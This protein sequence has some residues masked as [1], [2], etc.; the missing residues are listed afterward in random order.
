MPSS[1]VSDVDVVLVGAGI[2]CAT[3]GAL[4]AELQPDWTIAIFERLDEAAAESSDAWNNAG[5]GHSAFCELNYTPAGPDG[6]VDVS[7]ALKIAEQFEVSKQLWASLVHRGSLPDPGSFIRAIPH[8]S[9][10]WGEAHRDFLRR[11]YA[12]LHRSPLFK[13]MQYSE[14]PG[15][16]ARWAPLVMEGRSLAQPIAATRMGIGTDVNYGQLTRSLLAATTQRPGASLELAREVRGFER[17]PDGRWRV[18][19]HDRLLHS[20]REVRA[21]FVFIGAGGGSLPLLEK[22][23]IP[24]A[25]GYGGFPVSGQWLRCVNDDVITRHEA[26]VYGQAKVGA[27]PMSVPHLDTRFIDGRRQL[28]FGPYAG[29]STRFLKE[30]SWTDLFRSLGVDNIVPMT[31]AGAD[32]LDLTRYL[33]GQAL[34]PHHQRVA[35][36]REY[37]PA[38]RDDDWELQIAGMRVQIIKS[39]GQGGGVLQFGTEI[40]SA[41]DGSVAALLGASPGASTAASIMLEL[42]ERCFPDRIAEWAPRIRELVPSYGRALGEDAALCHQ[43]RRQSGER[44][45]LAA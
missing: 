34:L 14:D 31:R 28:L 42:V 25:K 4:L 5:T 27:P 20:D 44:L 2:M 23:G 7:K 40:V 22:T 43:V 26:K 39:D 33:V 12:A 18:A 6:R 35:M 8:V 19:V 29:F 11:R 10:V 30:G 15:V 45:R 24:E 21:R 13:G 16:V 17:E 32:N 1:E 41:A 36:L 9:F 3:L 37:Y 38:A